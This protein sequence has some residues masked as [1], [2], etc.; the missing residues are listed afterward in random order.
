MGRREMVRC[1][2]V[3]ASISRDAER[4][5]AMDGES[6]VIGFKGSGLLRARRCASLVEPLSNNNTPDCPSRADAPPSNY[7]GGKMNSEIYPADAY[8]KGQENRRS[9]IENIQPAIWLG[10]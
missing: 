7:V 8:Q 1:Q 4:P 5:T 2:A 9:N 6:A 10:P 3:G